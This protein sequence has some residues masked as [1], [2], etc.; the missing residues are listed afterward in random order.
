MMTKKFKDDTPLGKFRAKPLMGILRGISARNLEPLFETILS[1]GL[2]TVEITM[3]TEHYTD[4]QQDGKVK[5]VWSFGKWAQMETL[6]HEQVH[7]W[8]QNFGEDPVRLGRPYHNKEFVAKCEGLG[9]HPMP[10]VGTW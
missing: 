4:E 5:K 2:E 3:N 6:L 9:L 1:S 8:Q 7:L 10:G